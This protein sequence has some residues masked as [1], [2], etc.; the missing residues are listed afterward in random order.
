MF[1]DFLGFK[2][3]IINFTYGFNHMFAHL[4]MEL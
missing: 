1:A 2:E 4:L 3:L